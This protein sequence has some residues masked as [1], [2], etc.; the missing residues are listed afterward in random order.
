MSAFE[1]SCCYLHGQEEKKSSKCHWHFCCSHHVRYFQR[2]DWSKPA[3]S[4]ISLDSHESKVTSVFLQS[5]FTCIV[6]ISK[7]H[8]SWFAQPNGVYVY[9]YI[10]CVLWHMINVWFAVACPSSSVLLV[11]LCPPF[12][13]FLFFSFDF[14]SHFII[15]FLFFQSLIKKKNLHLFFSFSPHLKDKSQMRS[16]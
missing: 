3:V 8:L 9:I 16:L 2:N 13:L 10:M 11:L 14:H 6:C 15:Q 7:D 12:F 5:Y 1:Y 4:S